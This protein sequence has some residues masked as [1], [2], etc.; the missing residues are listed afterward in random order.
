MPVLHRNAGDIGH[1]QHA[2]IVHPAHEQ[3][4]RLRSEIHQDAPTGVLNGRLDDAVQVLVTVSVGAGAV[5]RVEAGQR[6]VGTV[7]VEGGKRHGVV[8]QILR[9]QPG[10]HRLAHAAFLATYK[11][12]A[13]QAADLQRGNVGRHRSRRRW[14]HVRHGN[15]NIGL[16]ALHAAKGRAVGV[17][18][19]WVHAGAPEAGS[20]IGRQMF[21]PIDQRR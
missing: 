7:A 19:G 17:V 9:H 4:M 15:G 21:S 16:A 18:G 6:A 20:D 2:G 5:F 8:D 3:I 14:Y 13:R 11:M 1:I 10:Q 12:N